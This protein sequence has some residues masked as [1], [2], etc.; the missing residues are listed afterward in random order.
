MADLSPALRRTLANEGVRFDE[1]DQPI[2]GKTGYVNHPADPGDETNYGITKAVAIENGYD[3]PLPEI[4]YTT[5]L[6]IYRKQYWDKMW[7][8]RI[9]SQRIAEKL[10]DVGVNCG[11]GTA[12]RFLQVTLTVLNKDDRLYPDLHIDGGMGPMTLAA[13]KVLL[14]ASCYEEA[15]LKNVNG[16]Q[17]HRYT[18]LCLRKPSLR[19]FQLGWLNR[20]D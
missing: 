8:D 3:G 18:D 17:V 10:F 9:P 16:L 12:V 6:D 2:P 13:L 20:T 1:Q 5:V 7:G 11:M 15:I 19:A 14:A 4:P